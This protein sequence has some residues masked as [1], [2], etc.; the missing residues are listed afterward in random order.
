MH[1]VHNACVCEISEMFDRAYLFD[2][3]NAFDLFDARYQRVLGSVYFG[4]VMV[5]FWALAARQS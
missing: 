4:F 2:D 5:R 3:F 1:K